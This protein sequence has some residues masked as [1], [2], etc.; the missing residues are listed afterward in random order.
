M[1]V[2]PRFWWTQTFYS[3]GGWDVDVTLK[4]GTSLFREILDE[5]N[6][7]NNPLGEELCC[8]NPD[9]DPI[10]ALDAI[11][12]ATSPSE[13]YWV[14]FNKNSV[15]DSCLAKD[16]E[17]EDSILTL[18]LD[19]LSKSITS[20]EDIDKITIIEY[21]N[22]GFGTYSDDYENR[23]YLLERLEPVI[24][25]MKSD[26]SKVT[27][28]ELPAIMKEIQQSFDD[29]NITDESLKKGIKIVMKSQ[30]INDF[31]NKL[32]YIVT[33]YTTIYNLQNNT[34][35]ESCSTNLTY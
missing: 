35:E 10:N 16:A 18:T 24:S 19:N 1:S 26:K 17:D 20:I 22:Q 25:K 28:N 29:F 23:A 3:S 8:N 21:V 2:A 13:L 7:C 9:W 6:E 31:I 32:D 34:A 12:N 30:D 4:N 15:D 5:N 14:L 11:K 27:E 33:T